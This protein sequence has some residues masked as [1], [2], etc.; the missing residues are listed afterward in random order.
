MAWSL[1]A[2]FVSRMMERF[3]NTVID[4]IWKLVRK[5]AAQCLKN[6]LH[7]EVRLTFVKSRY[8]MK[9][10][11]LTTK[12]VDLEKAIDR[13]SVTYKRKKSQ[14]VSQ[15]SVVLF[16]KTKGIVSRQLLAVGRRLMAYQLR[17]LYY[18]LENVSIETA[19]VKNICFIS[20]WK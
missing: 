10:Y 14:K 15:L 12:D 19:K 9:C 13:D 18:C 5:V 7:K 11:I 16:L 4:K 1:A 3:N 2:A 20:I 6:E 17:R 8:M